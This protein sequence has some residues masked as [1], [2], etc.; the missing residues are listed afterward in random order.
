MLGILKAMCTTLSHL[1]KK[2]TT[3]QYPE[4]RELLPERSRGL[5]RMVVDP[6]TGEPRCRACTVCE[7]TCPAQVIRVNYEHVRSPGPQRGAHRRG[8][9]GRAA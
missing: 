4:Q 3:V 2:K 9:S 1:P 6:E 5:I 7:T 8:A